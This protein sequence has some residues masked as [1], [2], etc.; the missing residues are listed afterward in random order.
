MIIPTMNFASTIRLPHFHI[1]IALKT[2]HDSYKIDNLICLVKLNKD[3]VSCCSPSV[4]YFYL[5][6]LSDTWGMYLLVSPHLTMP[7]NVIFLFV[8]RHIYNTTFRYW[9]SMV[10][11]FLSHGIFFKY[12]PYLI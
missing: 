8:F 3:D 5:V 4:W 6:S 7:A 11:F 1:C 9:I 10:I 2:V 12:Y